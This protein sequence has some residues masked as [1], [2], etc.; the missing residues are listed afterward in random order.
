MGLDKSGKTSILKCISNDSIDKYV[1]TYGFNIRNFEMKGSILNVWDIGGEK[2]LRPYWNTYCDE[3]DGCMFV[4]DTS[5]SDRFGESC[6]ELMN[7]LDEDVLSSVPLLIIGSKSDIDGGMN[8][9]ALIDKLC[10]KELEGR[11]WGCITT[12]AKSTDGIID[13]FKWMIDHV[14]MLK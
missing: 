11:E 3:C 9:D 4:I 14:V 10:L 8:K 7:I 1:P 5:D 2:G 6:D 12:S 13:A